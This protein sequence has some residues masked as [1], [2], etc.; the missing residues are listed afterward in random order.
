MHIELFFHLSSMSLVISLILVISLSFFCGFWE[1][2][3][4]LISTSLFN[5]YRFQLP[6]TRVSHLFVAFID[7]RYFIW[8]VFLL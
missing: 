6:G 1:N 8:H 4:N 7:L 3:P 5:F 2:F